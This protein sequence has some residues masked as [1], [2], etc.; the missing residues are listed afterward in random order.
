M[1]LLGSTSAVKDALRATEG[2]EWP[3]WTDAALSRYQQWVSALIEAETGATYYGT[4]TDIVPVA[5]AIEDV[6]AG[7]TLYLPLGL[8]SVTSIVSAPDWDGSAWSGGTTLLTSDYRLGGLARS[9]VYRIV[10][11][12]S[13]AWGGTAVITG[14]WEDQIAPVPADI[15]ALATYVMAEL[16]KK[17]KASPAGFS[18][19][20]GAT[21]PI[22]DVFKE[23]EV[24]KTIAANRIGVGVWF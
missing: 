2:D 16:Y 8:R 13:Y 20:D 15:D 1:A 10:R 18:G 9:G 21:V 4:I 5:R 3:A 11:G 19:P 22:R 14:I 6:P 24:K 7:D 23:S 17:Q 12:L